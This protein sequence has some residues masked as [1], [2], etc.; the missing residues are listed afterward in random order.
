MVKGPIQEEDRTIINIY[1]PNKGFPHSSVCKESACN[2][3]DPGLIPGLGRSTGE[4]IGDPLQYSWP[5]L[6]VQL[7]KNLSAIWETPVRFLGWENPLEK[8]KVTHSSILAW[9]IPLAIKSMGSQ[10][11]RHV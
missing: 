11:V 3:G 8:G 2:G 10:R 5:F 6:A 4:G 7:V 1:S 9:R